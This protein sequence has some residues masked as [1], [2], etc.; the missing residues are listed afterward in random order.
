MQREAK[1]AEYAQ[2]VD[3]NQRTLFHV[4]PFPGFWLSL[5]A[6]FFYVLHIG[7]RIPSLVLLALFFRPYFLIILLIFVLCNIGLS[8]CLLGRNV[9]KSLWWVS[10]KGPLLLWER[11]VVERSGSRFLV[12]AK[13]INVQALSQSLK[14]ARQT[15]PVLDNNQM[16]ATDHEFL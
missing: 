9:S 10:S 8:C 3:S 4:K 13:L 1:Q 7:C 16:V 6:L 5:K 12:T 14:S 11:V 15:V 2:D